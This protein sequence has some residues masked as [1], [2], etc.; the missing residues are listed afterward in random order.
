[1]RAAE[2]LLEAHEVTRQ[3]ANQTALFCTGTP[4]SY[5]KHPDVV[6]LPQT[7]PAPSPTPRDDAGQ[8]PFGAVLRLR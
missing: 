5:I 3:E 6:L 8:E 1:M 4:F 2:T 7:A